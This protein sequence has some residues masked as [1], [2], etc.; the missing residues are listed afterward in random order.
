MLIPLLIILKVVLL[1]FL[2]LYIC[3]CSAGEAIVIWPKINEEDGVEFI[4]IS[5]SLSCVGL[6]P[7]T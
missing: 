5:P 4:A 7:I 6:Y 1:T 3:T 2:G